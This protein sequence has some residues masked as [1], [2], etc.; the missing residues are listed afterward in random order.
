MP[1]YYQYPRR[2]HHVTQSIGDRRLGGRGPAGNR[3]KMH[4]R[5]NVASLLTTCIHTYLTRVGGYIG[6]L[7]TQVPRYVHEQI[8]VET[9]TYVTCYLLLET[10][11][12]GAQSTLGTEVATERM[13]TGAIN[14]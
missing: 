7:P 5:A 14:Q 8:D 4:V 12:Y 6:R 13:P 9:R 10:C 1:G 3:I 11:T 2:K